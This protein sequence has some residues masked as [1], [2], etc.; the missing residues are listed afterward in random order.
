MNN[1]NKR[2]IIILIIIIFFSKNTFAKFYEELEKTVIKAEIAEPI[3]KLESISETVTMNNFNKNIGEKEYDFI[4]KNYEIA[5][6]GKKKI[7][8]VNFN[9]FIEIKSTNNSFPV[10]YKLIDAQTAEEITLI[11]DISRE[12]IMKNGEEFERTYKLIIMWDESKNIDAN[13]KNTDIE[14]LVKISQCK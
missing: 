8:E 2:V 6:D 1:K 3:V 9:Y 11:N 7:S 12:I 10:K 13:E 5:K 4:I 14:I